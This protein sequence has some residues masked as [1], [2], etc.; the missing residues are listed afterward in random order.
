MRTDVEV[1]QR[2]IPGA[3]ATAIQQEALSSQKGGLPRKGFMLIERPRKP[4]S[5]SSIL[6]QPIAASVQ[7]MGVDDQ[8]SALGNFGK[9]SDGPVPPRGASRDL[10]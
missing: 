7:M 9:R 5:R 2:R 4:A 1:R 3:T 6:V 10:P 8:R